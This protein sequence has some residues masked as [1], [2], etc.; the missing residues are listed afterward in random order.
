[1][2]K[3][4]ILHATFSCIAT[5]CWNAPCEV[6]VSPGVKESGGDAKDEDAEKPAQLPMLPPLLHLPPQLSHMN[7]FA[8]VLLLKHINFFQNICKFVH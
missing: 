5:G 4:K 6:E 2:V 8:F 7:V 3:V 1:M